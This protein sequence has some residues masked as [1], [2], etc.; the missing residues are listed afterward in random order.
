MAMETWIWS[1]EHAGGVV[2]SSSRALSTAT[3]NRLIRAA[4]SDHFFS[5]TA[6]VDQDGDADVVSIGFPGKEAIAYLNPG[7]PTQSDRWESHIIADQ[8][9]NESPVMI[10][11]IPGRL[12]EL[13]CS[14]DGRFGYYQ[15]GEDGTQPWLW[16]GIS[17]ANVT[18]VPFGHGLGV[19]DVDGDG[20]LD[21]IDPTRWWKQPADDQV[22]DNWE[23]ST[24]ALEPYGGGGAQIL[25]HDVDGD[26]HNDIITSHNAHGYGLSWFAQ[27]VG[28]DNQRRFIRNQI[29]GESSIDNPFGVVFSQLHAL[30]LADIDR[31]GF[32]DIV[33]GKRW[34]AHGG[35][36]PG[37]NQAAVLYWFS[38]SPD[39]NHV[40]A[41]EPFLVDDDSGVG[42]EVIAIDLNQDGRVDIISSN[43]KG[44]TIHWQNGAASLNRKANNEDRADH[45]HADHEHADHEHADH[46]H[47]DHEHADHEHA[48][49]KL[50]TGAK[51]W[52]RGAKD[53]SAFA[54]SRS[55]RDAAAAME[56]PA[57]FSVDLIA[58]EPDLA[59]PIAMCF[60][61]RGRIWIAEGHTYPVAHR[62]DR[63]ATEF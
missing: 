34:W 15:A 52:D 6:D 49:G 35:N 50:Q 59:Q 11:L 38:G 51:R 8:V 9:S 63:D 18:H 58:S 47:A 4:D 12:P 20:R 24:W 56:I 48:G 53:D 30:A 7:E 3:G 36:D 41:F 16:H 28:D 32:Q 44:V 40:F 61:A 43:K 60:D 19:G 10:D 37:G 22:N 33:T 29:L 39:D 23:A 13:V 1:A 26:G 57:G 2:L 25:V 54:Q 21:I 5:F 45:E 31:D 55:P 46:E 14:R 27:K 62:R 42:T 17:E